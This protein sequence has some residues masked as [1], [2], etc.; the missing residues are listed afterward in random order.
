MRISLVSLPISD[1]TSPPLGIA[2]I[3]GYL[4]DEEKKQL[5]LFDLG[6]EFIYYCLRKSTLIKS[7]SITRDFLN[8]ENNKCDKNLKKYRFF[9]ECAVDGEYLCNNINSAIKLIKNHSTYL[10]WNRYKSCASIVE[11]ALKLFSIPYYPT[12]VS[13]RRI[14][15]PGDEYDFHNIIEIAHDREHNPLIGFYEEYISEFINDDTVFLGISINYSQQI[16]AA[17]TLV[18]IARKYKPQIRIIAGGAFFASFREKRKLYNR[19]SDFF[20]A[21]IPNAGEEPW[22]NITQTGQLLGVSGCWVNINGRFREPEI[23]KKQIKRGLPDFDDFCFERYLTSE[24]VLPYVMSVGCY[25]GKCA[26]C[27]YH[28]YKDNSVKRP[29]LEKLH[30]KILYDFH[31]LCSKYG[32]NRFF[33]VDEAIP[34]VVAGNLAKEIY[35]NKLPYHWYGEMRFEKVFNKLFTDDLRKGG[36]DLILWGLESG[37]DRVLSKMLKGTNK[38]EINDILEKCRN[39]DIRSMP[40]FFFGFPTET[41][42]EALETVQ[43]LKDNAL[44]IQYIGVGTFA[45]LQGCP[46]YENPKEFQ[47]EIKMNSRE[48]KYFNDYSVDEGMNQEEAEAFLNNLYVDKHLK[49]FFDYK[50]LSWNHLPLL[51][52]NLP[53]DTLK[54]AF[55]LNNEYML[56]KNCQFFDTDYDWFDDLFCYRNVH[57]VFNAENR[58]VFRISKTLEKVLKR[59]EMGGDIFNQ[60]KDYD[61]NVQI[62][63]FNDLQYLYREGIIV[64]REKC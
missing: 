43:L 7:L 64:E 40:M 23:N 38:K 17:L 47:I 13:C 20:D 21:I 4:S 15:F 60:L 31:K 50:V 11:R 58:E 10:S 19:F 25:W 32:V 57:Y 48:L 28:S 30:N 6:I 16:I 18:S 41:K 54:K 5:K 52:I 62:K 1:I 9:F 36:C 56:S 29:S 2:Q 26:F 49:K 14:V 61:E 46:V 63:L 51:P 35:E 8:D 27:S 53:N 34:P 37:N 42:E 45:L 12:V 24:I 33:I 3:K 44:N 59:L 39:S 22:K 55:C